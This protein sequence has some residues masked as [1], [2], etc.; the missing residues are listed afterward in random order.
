MEKEERQEREPYLISREEIRFAAFMT[1]DW[2]E[3]DVLTRDEVSRDELV[4]EEEIL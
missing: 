1:R 3:N 2:F 4:Q